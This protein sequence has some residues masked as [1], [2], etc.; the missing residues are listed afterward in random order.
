MMALVLM[1]HMSSLLPA[2]IRKPKRLLK[3]RFSLTKKRL[4]KS[5]TTEREM[6]QTMKLTI[7]K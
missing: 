7:M 3:R 1:R 2:L 6:A 4:R 5:L